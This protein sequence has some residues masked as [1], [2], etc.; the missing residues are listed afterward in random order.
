CPRWRPIVRGG[1]IDARRLRVGDGDLRVAKGKP[2]MIAR[3][4]IQPMM[5]EEGISPGVRIELALQLELARRQRIEMLGDEGLAMIDDLGPVL[6][7]LLAGIHADGRYALLLVGESPDA[8]WSGVI[9]SSDPVL[10]PRTTSGEIGP[11]KAQRAADADRETAIISGDAD[12]PGASSPLS[13]GGSRSGGPRVGP[14]E[15]KRRTLGEI[16]FTAPG[17]GPLRASMVYD[18]PRSVVVV[19]IPRVEGGY[20]LW[21]DMKAAELEPTKMKPSKETP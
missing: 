2:R 14:K 18:P 9:A 7:G 15:E 5:S 16:M 1:M 19:L 11:N 21:P 6:D 10:E 4:W 8:D 12:Q 13:G 17:S 20:R 3:A